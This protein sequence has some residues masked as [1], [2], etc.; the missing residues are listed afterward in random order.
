M[1]GHT[2]EELTTYAVGKLQ[3]GWSPEQI[4]ASLRETLA[5]EQW[6]H[7]AIEAM[8]RQ[9]DAQACA[10]RAEKSKEQPVDPAKMMMEMMQQMMNRMDA[11][12]RQKD[13]T[14]TP[15]TQPATPVQPAI[16]IGKKKYPDPEHF[17]GTQDKYLGWKY[18][19]QGKLA[20]DSFLY[21][22]D[23]NQKRYILSRTKDKANKSL[24]P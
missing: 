2:I 6:P 15:P 23:N 12:E 24:L 17:D 14:I 7:S 16:A 3:E 13:P 10:A 18:N 20:G 4:E 8:V 22:Q 1:K 5:N 19:C 21:P 9:V 11:L